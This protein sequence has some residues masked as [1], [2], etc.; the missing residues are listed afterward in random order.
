LKFT[1]NHGRAI[2]GNDIYVSVQADGGKAIASVRTELDAI[3]LA[4]DELSAPSDFY[5]HTFS[6]AGT[7]GPHTQHTLIVTAKL[8]DGKAHSATSLWSDPI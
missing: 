5:E 1:I 3:E 2:E 4:N 8:D 6:R 7:A